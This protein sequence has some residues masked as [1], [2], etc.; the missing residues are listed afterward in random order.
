M[1]VSRTLPLE[2]VAAIKFDLAHALAARWP[3][4]RLTMTANPRALDDETIL[5]RVQL[6]ASRRRLFVHH[7]AVQRLGDR[8]SVTLDL[9]VDGRMSLGEAHEIATRLEDAIENELGPQIEVETHIEPMESRELSG[10][11][12]DAELTS[13]FIETLRRAAG[14]GQLKDIHDVRLRVAERGY[15]GIFHC[16]VAP[17]TSVE[18]THAEV[19][20]LERAVRKEFPE[21]LRV[22]GHAEPMR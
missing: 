22:V 16:R 3:K 9:E 15:F 7:V 17:Q 5:E 14:E 21:I 12:A 2:R 13:R 18:T 1:F 10:R 11:D 8:T 4:M 6:I 20:A 19:D